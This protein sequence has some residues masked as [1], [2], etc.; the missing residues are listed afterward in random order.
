MRFHNFKEMIGHWAG[1][2]PEAPAMTFQYK[3]EKYVMDY[4]QLDRQLTAKAD[5]FFKEGPRCIGF[6]LGNDGSHL[7]IELLAAIR[8]RMRVVL[9]DGDAPLDT[10][11]E[12]IRAC[13]V[14][15]LAGDP[16]LVDELTPFLCPVEVT[17]R[18]GKVLFFTSGTTERAKAVV[19]TEESLCTSAYNGGA[20]LPLERGD[21]LLC[22]LP[23][24]HVFGLVCGLLWG[25]SCGACVALGRGMRHYLDDFDYYRP[26]AVSLVPLQLSFLLKNNCLNP[27]L[28]LTLIGAGDCPME[29]LVAAHRRG[30]R[31]CYGY[32]LTETSSGVALSVGGDVMAMEVCP[33]YTVTIAE[34][35]EILVEAPG[36]MMEGYYKHPED[37][38]AVLVDGVLHTGDLGAL[39]AQGRLYLTGRK[40]EMLV[41]PDGTKI[42]LPE[43]EREIA[44]AIGLREMAVIRGENGPVL[45]LVGEESERE[46]VLSALTSVMDNRPRNQQLR[47]I[48]FRTEPLPRTPTG[49][50]KRWEIGKEME[51]A[52]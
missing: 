21:I 11:K 3:G 42:F 51:I 40:K 17:E 44:G 4:A 34:D 2:T 14:D 1:T 24:N 27:E 32:G 9:L 19:L 15:S 52:P 37:T 12:Q 48:L 31:V 29:Y 43:Y 47:E 23:L 25:L 33:D 39:D 28:K 30:L 7:A 8:V 46:A 20:L 16:D 10:L 13:G 38:A 6:L 50:V 41:F 45:V 5:E 26:T 36:A 18:E 35:G 49:K 22:I